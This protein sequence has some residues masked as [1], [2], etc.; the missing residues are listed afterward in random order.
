MK[1]V[2]NQRYSSEAFYYGKEPNDFLKQNISLINRQG[3]VLCLAEGEGRNAVFLAQH[4]FK[5]TAVDLSE[6]GL[7][8]LTAFAKEKGV[9]E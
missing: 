6:V 9:R 7:E 4:G 8:K 5:V 2:W 3:E 1:E